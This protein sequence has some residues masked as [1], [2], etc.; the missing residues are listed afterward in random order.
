MERRRFLRNA[1][2]G[3][4]GVSALAGCRSPSGDDEGPTRTDSGNGT[5]TGAATTTSLGGTLRV[6]TYS[7]FTGEGTAGN[8]LKSAFESKYPDATVEFTTPENGLNQY[9]QRAN[10]GAPIDADLYV[11]LN[12]GELARADEQLD[13]SLFQSLREDV[14]GTDRIKG[15]LDIDPEGR[16]LPYDTGYISLVYDENEVAQPETFDALL[17]PEYEGDLI[18]QNAQQSDPGRAFLLWTILAKDVDGY[19]DY[20]QGL[21]DNGVTIMSDWEPAY[22]AYMNDEAPMIVSY[23]TDQVYYHGEDVDM[24]KHQVGFLED[25]GYANPEALAMFS[26]ASN[27]DLGRRFVEFVL[28]EEAQA[29]IAER[30]V[31][32]PAVE[33]VEMSE[34]FERY[35][36][37]PPEPVTFTYEE[38]AGN[39]STWIEDWARQVASK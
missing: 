4:V 5:T 22:E 39:V 8:W 38:L 1:G 24:A 29:E 37:E 7:S 19:L 21:Q 18:V 16:A 31:Q 23:S 12:T 25:Q 2:A 35:A 20:W 33:G 9:V 14:A 27:G 3:I 26:S 32:F 6:A 34:E 30:N 11:G 10:E 17:E 28:S 36:Y 13:E 15:G